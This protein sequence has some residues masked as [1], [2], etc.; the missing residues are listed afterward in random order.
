M[1]ENKLSHKVDLGLIALTELKFEHK[2]SGSSCLESI[3]SKHG[4]FIELRVLNINL[5]VCNEKEK[6]NGFKQEKEVSKIKET[7]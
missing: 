2:I 3:K 1:I 5:K 4:I 6:L 7:L